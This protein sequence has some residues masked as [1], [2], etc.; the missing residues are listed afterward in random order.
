MTSDDRV[1]EA[2][3]AYRRLRLTLD[4]EVARDL[5][6]NCGLSMPDYDVLSALTELSGGE[7]CVRVRGLAEHL[8]WAHSRL[9]RQLGRMEGRDLIARESCGLDGRGEDVVLTDTGRRAHEQAA[10]VHLASVRHRLADRLT[11]DQLTALTTIGLVLS[12]DR[13]LPKVK[14]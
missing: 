11:P 12:A 14:G 1:R 5:E 9:S 7:H 2:W 8:G 6:R 13:P 4:A 3:E 10:P